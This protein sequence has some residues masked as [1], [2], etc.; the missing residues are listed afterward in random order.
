MYSSLIHES[1]LQLHKLG[2]PVAVKK[3]VEVFMASTSGDFAARV[4]P[5][6]LA[7]RAFTLR[8]SG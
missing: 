6:A 4:P 5:L 3:I 1:P 8:L 2:E 7:H